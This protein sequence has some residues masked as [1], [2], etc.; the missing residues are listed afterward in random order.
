VTARLPPRPAAWAP[1]EVLAID[2]GSI[3]ALRVFRAVPPWSRYRYVRFALD[4][5]AETTLSFLAECFE[6]LGG[7]PRTVLADRPDGL[8]EGRRRREQGRANG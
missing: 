3:G 2:W 5:K 8:P 1:G 7:V 4:E 6:E